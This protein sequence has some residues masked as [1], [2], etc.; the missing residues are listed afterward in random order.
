MIGKDG[1]DFVDAQCIETHPAAT[2]DTAVELPREWQV[3]GPFTPVDT[4]LCEAEKLEATAVLRKLGSIPDELVIGGEPRKAKSMVLAGDTLD[5]EALFGGRLEGQQ[6]FAFAPLELS[7]ESELTFGAGTE[8]WM[9]WWIDGEAVYDSLKKEGGG[10]WVP[11]C[12]DHVFCRR[13]KAGTHLLAVWLVSTAKGGS[14]KEQDGWRLKAAIIPQEEALS[15]SRFPDN[16][17]FLPDTDEIHPPNKSSN[18]AV[19]FNVDRCLTDETIECEFRKDHN[20]GDFGIILGAQDSDQYYYVQIPWHGQLARARGVWAAIS[21]TDGSGYV[22]NLALQLMP[23]V[24]CVGKDWMSLKV[25]RSGNCIQMWLNG[26]KGPGVT[27]T[28]YGAGRVGI[29][30]F[31]TFQVRNLRIDGKS[32]NGPPWPGGD[33]RVRP[34][35]HIEPDLDLGDVQA[36]VGLCKI[37]GEIL[38]V[39]KIGRNTSVASASAEWTTYSY[40]SRD[41]GRTWQRRA[42]SSK[43]KAGFTPGEGA[44]IPGF[45]LQVAPGTIRAWIWNQDT[46]TID[47]SDSTDKAVTWSESTSCMHN[48]DWRDFREEHDW[49]GLNWV[50]KLKDGTMLLT[51]HCGHSNT[52]NTIKDKTAMT[53]PGFHTESWSS[54]SGDGG[55]SWSAP[56]PN[57][58]AASRPDEPGAHPNIDMVEP[59]VAQLPSGRIVLLARP[60]ASPFMWQ[61]HSD[62]GGKTWSMA[63]YAPFTGA[64][65]PNL[66]C[67]KSGYLVV[68]KRGPG[69]TLAISTDGGV[70]WDQGTM[71]DYQGAFNGRMVEVEPDVVLVVYPEAMDDKRPAYVRAQLIRITPDGPTPVHPQSAGECSLVGGGA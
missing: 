71:I 66:V 31:S 13:L 27:D 48:G 17:E 38:A 46:Q 69:L 14:L 62:D 20:A 35:F 19:A 8:W 70:N 4:A 7:Q 3:F 32:V 65:Y 50:E 64:G 15:M 30:G 39:V 41:R 33:K 45:P 11:T 29:A 23:N 68:A 34:W 61:T 24:P 53:W 18:H 67:T 43:G 56:R 40:S 58:L 60:C 1:W 59:T 12:R 54:L 63:C 42:G 44:V 52:Y 37:D 22:R 36:S 9:Q 57:D 5:F 55:M 51:L 6:A 10:M 28:T 16:W 26:V 49:W 25:Q 47:Y 21:K 2:T